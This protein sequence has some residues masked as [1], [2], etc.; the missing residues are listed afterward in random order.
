MDGDVV[1]DFVEFGLLKMGFDFGAGFFHFFLDL[2][3]EACIGHLV[4]YRLG[5]EADGELELLLFVGIKEL[6]LNE[7]AY[8]LRLFI[9][10]EELPFYKVIVRL[11][12]QLRVLYY[13][14]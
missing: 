14:Y 11:I 13:L 12:S 1:V 7:L 8:K 10:L 9:E 4:K 5:T 3:A 6:L 2:A